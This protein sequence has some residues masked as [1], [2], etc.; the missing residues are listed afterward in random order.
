MSRRYNPYKAERTKQGCKY[1]EFN[2][3]S[4][5]CKRDGSIRKGSCPCNHYKASWWTVLKIKV[6]NFL[7][8]IADRFC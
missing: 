3:E 5:Y 4:T 1:E 2:S 7:Y 6:G 8:G